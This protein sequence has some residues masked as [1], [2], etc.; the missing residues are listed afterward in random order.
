MNIMGHLMDCLVKRWQGMIVMGF[1]AWAHRFSDA[2]NP[3]FM[4]PP[5]L[6][7]DWIT[8]ETLISSKAFKVMT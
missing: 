5:G 3:H 2:E 1:R 4:E 8:K 7:D 6:L